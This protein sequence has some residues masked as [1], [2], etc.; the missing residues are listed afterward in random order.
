MQP[1]NAFQRKVVEVQ[2]KLKPITEEQITWAFENVFDKAGTQTKNRAACF[3]CG[4]SWNQSSTLIVTLVGCKCPS[5]G[6]ELKME[7]TAKKKRHDIDYFAILTTVG[8]FQ[9]VRMIYLTKYCK[10]GQPAN[11]CQTEVM[12]HWIDREGKTAVFAKHV[13]GFS[14]CYDAWA[15]WSDLELRGTL[16]TSSELRNSIRPYK[17]Y[18]KRKILDTIKRNGFKGHFHDISPV[19][20]FKMIL[21]DSKAETLIKSNQA[22]VLKYYYDHR[23]YRDPID[24]YWNSIK[25]C[26]RN[27]YIIKDAGTWVDYLNMLSFFNKDLLSSHYICPIDLKDSHDRLVK[28]HREV[29]KRRKLEQARRDLQDWQAEYEK[30][31]GKFFGISFSEGEITVKVLETVEEFQKE[32][33]LLRH[34]LFGSGYYKKEGSLCLSARIE[35]QPIETIEI[36]LSTL[37]IVQARGRGNQA[38]E[39]HE[40]IVNLVN[41]NLSKISKL[42]A[43]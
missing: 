36:S 43:S 4:H 1:K 3:E 26:I 5:C 19:N 11:L 8:E 40:K 38:T 41:N 33:E 25:I 15:L 2:K 31:K 21:T 16:S 14:N 17:I 7:V 22:S 27:N 34:C 23:S 28:K 12:Q 29:S 42:L 24:K 10:I 9:V 32:S 37:K 35:D 30:Q 6:K 13:N 20:L 39:H 18:P